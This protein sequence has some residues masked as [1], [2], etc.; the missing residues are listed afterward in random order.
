MGIKVVRYKSTNHRAGQSDTDHFGFSRDHTLV[1]LSIEEIRQAVLSLPVAFFMQQAHW[2]AVALLGIPGQQNLFVDA[3]GRWLDG[4]QP[5][6]LRAYPFSLTRHSEEQLV[7]C[8]DEASGLLVDPPAG[9]PL[10]TAQ[11]EPSD[12]LRESM[13]SRPSIERASVSGF[14]QQRVQTRRDV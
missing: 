2:Q 12:R 4:Y 13:G 1:A 8:L 14:S 9:E 5:A 3:A 7:L 11:G 10:F 6:A